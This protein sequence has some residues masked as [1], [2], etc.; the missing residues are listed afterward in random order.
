MV[1]RHNARMA[2]ASVRWLVRSREYTNLTYD[3]TPLNR[4]H[5]AWFVAVVTD[6]HIA[7]IRAYLD[8]VESDTTLREHIRTGTRESARRGIA[9][10]EARYG[11]RVGWYALVRALRP[12]HVVET[13]T[14]KGLGSCVLAAALQRNGSGQLTTIDINP[15]SGYLIK[16]PYRTVIERRVGDSLET[17]AQLESP[18]DLFLHDS[19]H[20][21]DYEAAEYDAVAPNLTDLAVVLSDNAHVTNKLAT[22]A[23][24]NGRKFLFF[25]ERPAAHWYAGGGIGLALPRS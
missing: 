18:V 24:R 3:L 23:E 2:A 9:D 14:D 17:L 25:D 15:E 1:G 16:L 7:E 13:G 12:S 4:E 5:L 21:P 10:P 6:V 8:E 20:S 11:R 22:W 19:D